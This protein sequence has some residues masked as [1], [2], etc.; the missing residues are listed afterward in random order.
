MTCIVGIVDNDVAY[1]AS[2]SQITAGSDI[3]SHTYKKIH[4]NKDLVMGI[5]GSFTHVPLVEKIFNS[6]DADKF[7]NLRD[8][9]HQ[10]FYAPLAKELSDKA[11]MRNNNWSGMIAKGNQLIEV[12]DNHC[13][14]QYTVSA[15][16]SG[17][18]AAR[19]CLE[20]LRIINSSHEALEKIKLA[21]TV[22]SNL[23]I[24]TDANWYYAD[25]KNLKVKKLE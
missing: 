4:I 8:D 5:S 6:I 25:T 14:S 21:M 1:I 12:S 24:G 10:M 19:A 3:E 11:Y 23:D 7:L 22:A 18:Y 15:I 20:T 13:I 2:D 16:G 17:R 9:V